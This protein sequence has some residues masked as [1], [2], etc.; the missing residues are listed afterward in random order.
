M[1]RSLVFLALAC[2]LL[3]AASVGTT[4]DLSWYA[5]P[6]GGGNVING[7]YSLDS[8]IGQPVAG[9]IGNQTRAIC[10]GFLCGDLIWAN[11]YLP[12]VSK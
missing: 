11:I 3:L 6:S 4:Y 8:V 12:V 2:L 5:L 7:I 10:A 9:V 1:K